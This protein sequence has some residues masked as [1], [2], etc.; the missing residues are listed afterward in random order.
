MYKIYIYIMDL[1]NL[2]A[3]ALQSFNTIKENPAAYYTLIVIFIIAIITLIVR[4]YKKI[5]ARE[6]AEPIFIRNIKNAYLKP[7][8]IPDTELQSP[9]NG[10]S[11]S[12]STWL[13]VNDFNKKK[14]QLKHV[15]H[16]GDVN[17][18]TMAPGVFIAPDI[19]SIA[20]LVD[21]QNRVKSTVNTSKQLNS[22]VDKV[23]ED[24][25][26]I[27][28]MDNACGCEEILKI[29]SDYKT[30]S[31]V[32]EDDGSGN[33]YLFSKERKTIPN[34]RAVTWTKLSGNVQTMNPYNN[35]MILMDD[36]SCVTVENIPLQRWFHLA[37]VI[38][39]SSVEVYVDGKLYKTLVLQ[40]N[41]K[42]NS[43]GLHSGLN[44]GYDGMINELRYF[45]HALR[46][47]DVYNMYSRGP[48]PFY[49]MY[50]FR[51]K[52]E[53]Y[54]KHL[55]ELKQSLKD[56]GDD[57]GGI[58]NNLSEDIFGQAVDYTV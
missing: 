10:T 54:D 38:N 18:N 25:Q 3:N 23:T 51:G 32:K 4:Q 7:I 42:L 15:F 19:N 11:F 31:F 26:G 8:S 44:D 55:K 24:V 47:I 41:V 37:V 43:G 58:V 21:T 36:N 52:T 6:K 48:T 49:F 35:K 1:G 5:V 17:M 9:N 16:K 30:A 50:M 33:C 45:P 46:Y 13:Y 28:P 34:D 27:F 2:Q 56:I 40:S 14:N 29:E 22:S 53:L 12:F 20:I 57:A 39:N